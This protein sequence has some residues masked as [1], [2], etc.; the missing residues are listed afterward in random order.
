MTYGTSSN[1]CTVDA[2]ICGRR[3][4]FA[5]LTLS[6]PEQTTN[7]PMPILRPLGRYEVSAR[8]PAVAIRLMD[9]MYM[10]G[11][12]RIVLADDPGH[13]LIYS[14]PQEAMVEVAPTDYEGPIIA[15]FVFCDAAEA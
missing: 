12:L 3:F 13:T 9:A 11:E 14:G 7:P 15:S 2:Y 6:R 5:A 8:G 10:G 1:P 4:S